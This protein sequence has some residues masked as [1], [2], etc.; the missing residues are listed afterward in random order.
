MRARQPDD[1]GLV[2]RGGVKIGYEVFG[3]GPHTVVFAPF[4][5][6]VP[7]RGW[8]MQVPYLSRHCRVVTIDGRAHGRSDHPTDPAA[9]RDF[10]FAEDIIGVMDTVGVDRA[11][12]IGHC[13]GAWWSTLAA[14][15]HPERVDGI[16]TIAPNSPHLTRTPEHQHHDFLAEHL[17]DEG[18]A[19][20]NL[21]SWRRD[22]PGFIDFYFRAL[23]D[24]PHSSKLIEDTIGWGNDA[25]F[26]ALGHITLQ[27]RSVANA[28]ETAD[29]LRGLGKPTFTVHGRGDEC[30]PYER[31]ER[32][33]ELTGGQLMTLSTGGHLP[34]AR[35]PVPVNRWILEF[36]EQA[37]QVHPKK[38]RRWTRPM[39]RKRRVLFLSSP[40]G[41]GHTRRDL[42]I[43]AELRALRP[44]VTIDWL[45]QSPVAEA[46]VRRGE[47]VHP[48]SAYLASESAHWEDEADEHDLHAFQSLR[49]MDE[50]LMANFGVFS[51]LVEDEPYDLWI[52]D[53]A[54][55]VDYYLHENPELKRAP[56]AW[57]TDFVGWLPMPDGGA[58]EAE[59]TA[60]YNA[61][62]IEQIARFPRLRDRSLFVGDAED[63]VPDS[64]GADL[65]SIRGWTREHFAFTGYITGFASAE[66]AD[67]AAMRAEFG[68]APDEPV[69]IVT[70]GG[71]GVGEHLMRRILAAYPRA[72]E[73][74]P[75]LR[76]VVVTGPRI[77][78]ASFG[79]Q[80][81]GVE[82]HAFLPDLYRYL[83]AS[84][85]AVVQGGLTTTMEL[86]AAGRPFLYVPIRHHF[87]QNFHVPHRLARYGSGNRL[88]YADTEPEPLARA[89]AAHIGEP[90]SY[91]PVADDGAARAARYLSELF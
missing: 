54:W 58:A 41:L 45:A 21:H 28:E 63:I 87:E 19:R 79:P 44:D 82:R 51:D 40:I 7:S 46:L 43:A 4:W 53:E 84:D 91:R 67:R 72:A 32:Y 27:P 83:A 20:Y 61:E 1:E 48:A 39:D 17:V 23:L 74:V 30:T 33:S 2:E 29:L 24:D 56:Y 76:M 73:L 86:T 22:F 78:P 35:H 47:R 69:C 15:R 89:I 8:K 75:G 25:D 85:L 34:Q 31:G 50:I 59:L 71:T 80:P 13:S 52:G 9:Y 90:V 26:E 62:M 36:A 77:D 5:P 38:P 49:R 66:I 42:A 11:V 37:S 57:L 10:E 6:I 18:W 64:F 65:P 70:V 81:A 3:T 55:E 12:L 14:T 16:F 60:D 68:W 88:A